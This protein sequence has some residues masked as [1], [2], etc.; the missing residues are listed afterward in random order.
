MLD[1]HFIMNVPESPALGSKQYPNRGLKTHRKRVYNQEDILE[2]LRIPLNPQ[3]FPD[4]VQSKRCQM[5]GE[6]NMIHC[7]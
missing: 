3:S 2:A 6:E 1:G 7:L 4:S 5:T